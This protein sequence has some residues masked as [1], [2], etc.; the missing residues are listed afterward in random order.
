MFKKKTIT[1]HFVPSL[2]AANV[3]QFSW[4]TTGNGIPHIYF[5]VFEN[6]I[7]NCKTVN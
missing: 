3:M 2:F 7:G 1:L 6:K 5:F 4:E